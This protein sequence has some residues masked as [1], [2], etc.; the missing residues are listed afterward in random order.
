MGNKRTEKMIA[1]FIIVLV[2]LFPLGSV[3]VY[4]S[5]GD[6]AKFAVRGNTHNVE[7]FVAENERIKYEVTV[8]SG[9]PDKNNNLASRIGISANQPFG[10]EPCITDATTGRKICAL[11]LPPTTD[12]DPVNW[13]L[14]PDE[15]LKTHSI[16]VKLF[17]APGDMINNWNKAASNNGA[18]DS[19]TAFYTIE[20]TVP[21]FTE[22]KIDP[23]NKNKI[24]F[25]AKD[26][27]VQK[28]EDERCAGLKDI[29]FYKTSIASANLLGKI[30]S[31]NS[32]EVNN[33]EFTITGNLADGSPANFAQGDN[34]IIA[35]L[36]DRIGHAPSQ[37]R[38]VT[39]KYD[40]EPPAVAETFKIFKGE[41]ELKTRPPENKPLK[42]IKFRIEF[43][44][45]GNN[46]GDLVE[47]SVALV[48]DRALGVNLPDLRKISG[49]NN[50]ITY[51]SDEMTIIPSAY[52]IKIF[53]KADDDDG[54]SFG[55]TGK[56]LSS[57][58]LTED[59]S[60]EVLSI[61][62]NNQIFTAGQKQYARTNGNKINVTFYEETGLSKE[63]VFIAGKKADECKQLSKISDPSSWNC[64]WN[65]V[66]LKEGTL[67]L[68]S[69]TTDILGNPIS[70]NKDVVIVIDETAPVVDSQTDIE[71]IV[72][73]TNEKIGDN[74]LVGQ[75]VNINVYVKDD[76]PVKA[77][78]DFTP[79]SEQGSKINCVDADGKQGYKLCK[80]EKITIANGETG[81]LKFKITDAAGNPTSPNP[82][83]TKPITVSGVKNNEYWKLKPKS[84]GQK[85]VT[86]SPSNINR[87]LSALKEQNAYCAVELVAHD[88]LSNAIKNSL[89]IVDVRVANCQ[90]KAVN[91]DGQ[92]ISTRLINDP[93]VYR[94][95]TGTTTP[96]L[97]PVPIIQFTFNRGDFSVDKIKSTCTLQIFSKTEEGVTKTP[98][99]ETIE[100]EFG[101]FDLPNVAA[102]LNEKIQKERAELKEDKVGKTV[103]R[104]RKLADYSLKICTF[105]QT[106]YMMLGMLEKVVTMLDN[107][108]I[109]VTTTVV[110]APAAAPLGEAKSATCVSEQAGQEAGAN[111]QGAGAKAGLQA[112]AKTG[113]GVLGK[114]KRAFG[115]FNQGKLGK[116]CSYLRC[117]YPLLNQG[118]LDAM[119][120]WWGVSHIASAS[121][122]QGDE[123]ESLAKKMNIEDSIISS[124]MFGCLPGIIKNLDE[125]KQIKCAY[126]AC[127][128]K[129]VQYGQDPRTCD[130]LRNRL[131]CKYVVG[132]AF[133]LVPYYHFL[134]SLQDTIRQIIT[135]PFALGALVAGRLCV[136]QCTPEPGSGIR[137][138]LCVLPKWT[139]QFAK[140]GNAVKEATVA[141]QSL[142]ETEIPNNQC[143]ALELDK[144]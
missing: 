27:K 128:E 33:G 70:E 62:V 54:N 90:H 80:W 107:A 89:E 134:N 78:A 3:S 127:L 71:V 21:Y 41:I 108:Q 38:T 30:P 85:P 136:T 66:T 106:Y 98:E 100:V 53:V 63:E 81:E 60:L 138:Y 5:E 23:G 51:E 114:T 12:N 26:D 123:Q 1:L 118:I 15:N 140:I 129:D 142:A 17:N 42:G 50:K 91:P 97:S 68:D 10:T 59:N 144:R 143:E 94:R 77:E 34:T 57:G 112:G 47:N 110:G 126:V 116:F 135:N 79:F 8:G 44:D 105:F 76:N 56:E 4:A 40:K 13:A 125:Y 84:A 6:I 139:I 9:V 102:A 49:P 52:P 75:T 74:Y 104:L 124:I 16:E 121:T 86:C 18:I 67:T 95:A 119:D 92:E 83:T 130:R 55:D 131:Y 65:S 35:K 115:K 99:T 96:P 141:A 36:E 82:I 19:E 39:Y 29:E 32:C 48:E 11:V 133:S 69:T 120:E 137:Y 87:R 61:S 93:I 2:V 37:P 64:I 73:P 109:T 25:A 45:S 7:G 58:E 20:N 28:K 117:D 14:S 31:Q 122:P 88:G 111:L 22:L 43:D 132:E 113:G 103:R 72:V 101:L 46:K 24:L